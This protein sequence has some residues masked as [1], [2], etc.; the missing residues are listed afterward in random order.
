M[1]IMAIATSCSSDDFEGLIRHSAKGQT[2]TLTA[3]VDGDQTRVGMK[4]E[5]SSSASFY[6]HKNDKILVQTKKSDGTFTGTEFTTEAATGATSA[7]FTGEVT[8]TVGQ[9]AVYPYSASHKFD[10]STK[11]KL[12][13]HLPAE[14]TY[15]TVGSN[16]FSKD[17]TCPENSTNMPMLGTI[18][19]GKI[20]FKHLG[21]LAVIRIDKMPAES[22]TITITADQQL[23]GDFNVEDLSATEPQITT[24]SAT[25]DNTVKFAFNG[26]TK[27]G[28]GVFYLP[29][30]TGSYSN[31][32]ITVMY[33]SITQTICYGTLNVDRKS[34]T[35]IPLYSVNGALSKNSST[36]GNVYD[37]AAPN[38]DGVMIYYNF[39]WNKTALTVTYLY[40]NTEN[41]FGA[42][43]IPESVIYGEKT[44]PV[45]AVGNNAFS[46]CVNL[47]SVV[48]PKS[49]TSI[50]SGAFGSCSSLT[51]IAIPSGVT[52]IRDDTFKGC[53]NLTSITIPNSVTSIGFYAFYGCI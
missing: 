10:E 36:D 51:S 30:A 43:S 22:G 13:Y 29:L 25:T 42:V 46:G 16:I 41:Y 9:Y 32:K 6:W 31:V 4:K 40:P 48:I 19:D 2:V 53:S 5:S 35:A 47:T 14:Y 49:V 11:T 52:A 44:Y 7:T 21:G 27:E 38:A 15:T 24:A 23:S 33:N 8:G 26:A 18:A 1:A 34:V 45:T 20:A 28:I 50:G 39:N 17:D 37:I 12:T 3:S